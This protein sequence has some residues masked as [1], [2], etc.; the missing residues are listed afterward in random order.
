MPAPLDEIDSDT[1]V[2][3]RN[4]VDHDYDDGGNSAPVIPLQTD[5]VIERVIPPPTAPTEA[6][7]WVDT[8][9]TVTRGNDAVR[10][11]RLTFAEHT[12]LRLVTIDEHGREQLSDWAPSEVGAHYAI[13]IAIDESGE[14]WLLDTGTQS[15]E[16]ARPIPNVDPLE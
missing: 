15:L 4:G 3:F 11:E 16:I 8:L 9:I 1:I 13:A 5:Q 2:I 12:W 7:Q 10:V 6:N 14:R